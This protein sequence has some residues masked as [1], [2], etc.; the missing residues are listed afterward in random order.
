MVEIVP[1]VM[2]AGMLQFVFALQWKQ[3]KEIM[4]HGGVFMFRV[5]I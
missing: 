4:S 5:L 3:S 2:E 1:L